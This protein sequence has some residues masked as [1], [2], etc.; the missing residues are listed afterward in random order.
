M[1]TGVNKIADAVQVTLGPKGRN[2]VIQ[3]SWGAPQITKDG[4]TV[5]KNI[6]L[7]NNVEDLGAQLIKNVANKTNDI[8]GDGTTTA[9]ILARAIYAEGCKRVAASIN[10][11]DLKRGI[12]LAVDEVISNLQSITKKVETGEEIEQVA[13][14]SANND[15]SIGK[16]IARAFEEVGKN[17]TVTVKDGNTLTDDL[18]VTHGMS[19]DN[20]YIS[21]AFITDARSKK[22]VFEDAFV[23]LSEKKLS[24]GQALLPLLEQVAQKRKAL[25]IIAENVDGDALATLILNR[26]R[27]GLNVCVVKAPMFGKQRKEVLQDMSV[28][29]GGRVFRGEDFE[30]K[31]E[32]FTLNDLGT[33]R[34]I[35][36][37]SDNTT[38]VEGAGTK[39]QIDARVAEI[40]EAHANSTSEYDKEKLL[41]RKAKLVGGVAVLRIGGAS[42]VEVSE[43]KDRVV[44]ALNA[45]R[46]ALEEGIVPGG[47][48]ALLW[49]SRHITVKGDNF[50]QDQGIN[51]VKAACQIPAKTIANNAGVEG[52][53]IVGELMKSKSHE[54]GY[55]AQTGEIVDMFKAGIVDPTKVVRTALLDASSVSGLMTTT[56]A[57]IVDLPKKEE[58]TSSPSMGAGMGGGMF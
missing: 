42:E 2:V 57:V 11:M 7:E 20:G 10:P 3:K 25:V 41:E 22:A 39:E 33:A 23:L 45:T 47:G 31:L 53:V 28:L 52:S 36:I 8:A 38:I 6:D 26:L 51:I 12:T 37:T 21:P 19:F 50:D 16:L 30:E 17:G 54:I 40:D 18:E 1:L 44:D 56:E 24:S 55:N 4:V 15:S 27:G 43:K 58:P 14:I 49:A 5:A 32:D 29:L 34:S 9:T 46:A 13:T 35:E 48:S